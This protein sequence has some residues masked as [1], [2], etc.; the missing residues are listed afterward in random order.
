MSKVNQEQRAAIGWDVLTEA[1][2]KGNLVSYGEL[3]AKIGIHHRVVRHVLGLIQEYCLDRKLPPLTI[4]VINQSGLPGTGF[5]AWEVDD[6]EE[7][8]VK[9]HNHNWFNEFNPFEYARKGL[10]ESKIIEELLNDPD[11]S[12][13]RYA[14]VKVRGVAQPIFRQVLLQ[15]YDYQCAVCGLTFEAALHAAHIKPW[16][17]ANNHERLDV[18]NGLLLCATHHSL[19]DNYFLTISDDYTINFSDPDEEDGEYSKYD[20]LL[21]TNFHGKKLILPEQTS[22]WPKLE[23]LKWH[24]ED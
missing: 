12:D 16:A 21:T 10:T 20:T 2:S 8:R 15:A 18:R 19:F 23:H 5:I 9:V 17:F 3:G 14:Q 13:E 7:G 1:A 22:H 6:F 11:K 4:L 24:R